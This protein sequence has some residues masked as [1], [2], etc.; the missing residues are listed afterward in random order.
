MLRPISTSILFVLA[1][2]IIA[3][4]VVT[5]QPS[6]R[7]IARIE[8]EGLQRLPAQEVIAT[9]GLKTGVPFS[10]DE[11]DAAGSKLVE[12]GLFAKVGYR[13]KTSGNDVTVTFQV[14]E[15]KNNLSPVSFD[16]FVWFTDAELT[17]AI[18]RAVP[19]YNGTAADSGNST[20]MIKDALQKLLDEKQIKGTVE[21]A[22]WFISPV[23]Q[24]HMFSVN[25]VN[26]PICKLEFPGSHNITEEI[27]IKSSKQLTDADYS[28]KSAV[29][30]S[31]FVLFPLYR[32][33]GQLRASFGE[34]VA[35]F[36]DSENCKAGV[37]VTM[38][39]N[40]G[41]I[42]RWNKAEWVG[43]RVLSTAELDA[44]IGFK[45]GDVANGVKIDKGL[46]EIERLYGQSGHLEAHT[47]AVPSFD[48]AAS[49]V[50]F[51]MDVSEGPQYKMGNLIITGLSASE[52]EALL[53]TWKLKA[54]EVF[55]SSYVTKF[56]RTDARDVMQRI[57]FARQAAGKSPPQ[58]TSTVK[59]NRQNLLADVTIEFK[60]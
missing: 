22:P 48:D 15:A 1:I 36:E 27:L 28:M 38:P 43:N 4:S 46:V 32:E 5:G 33:V 49:T 24:E 47:R 21:Y 9:S 3:A 35:K 12:S 44:A 13:T 17:A 39:V 30:F 59:P 52:T 23:M 42:Y 34:P 11:V 14:E 2:V 26:I 25:G 45:S 37:N 31:K 10:I 16:N 58:P 57:F 19:S 51:R 41:P 40:E 7:R 56:F 60:D 53:A 8:I 55:N 18:K 6:A 50:N 29:A 20:D 54:G